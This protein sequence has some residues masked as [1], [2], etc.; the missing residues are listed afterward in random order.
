MLKSDW[1]VKH[2]KIALIQGLECDA[3]LWNDHSLTH[4]YETAFE[5]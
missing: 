5:G 1:W 3:G 4:S 2:S